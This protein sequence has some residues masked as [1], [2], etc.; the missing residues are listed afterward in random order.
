MLYLVVLYLGFSKN[1]RFPRFAL[2]IFAVN[3]IYSAAMAL[4]LIPA[5]EAALAAFSITVVAVV[6]AVLA[7]MMWYV[8]ASRRVNLTYLHRVRA[9]D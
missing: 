5:S 6:A 3:L 2:A 9:A 1:R 8:A 4:I 7:L